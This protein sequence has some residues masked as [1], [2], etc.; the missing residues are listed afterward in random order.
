MNNQSKIEQF[1]QR[2]VAGASQAELEIDS[3]GLD[4]NEVDMHGRTP[5]MVSAAEGLLGVAEMLV[6]T[7]A[8]VR[9]TGHRAMT[10]LH[11]ASANGEAA[12][13]TYLLSVGAEPNAETVDGVTPLMCAAAWGNAKVAK[14]LLDN[15]AD[16][17][18]TDR[19]GATAADIAR[20][21][22]END[23]ADLINSYS[24]R[25]GAARRAD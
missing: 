15:C 7:G 25:R 5:L 17:G 6:R 9:A 16:P 4:L 21:K 2:I 13:V 20:E 22:G 12:V 14:L 8:S 18:K 19:K 3:R 11:E 1:I 23:T 10:A 24:W